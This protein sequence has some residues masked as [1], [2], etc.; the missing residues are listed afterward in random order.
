MVVVLIIGMV[1]G[2]AM[3]SWQMMLPRQQLNSDVRALAA[4]IQGTRSEAIARNDEFRLYYHLDEDRY[5]VETPYRVG[6]GFV[7]REVDEE[8]RLYV[9]ETELSSGVEFVSV[10][11][12]DIEYAN[13]VVFVRFDPLAASSAHTVVLYQELFDR[14]F[15]IEVLA[16][17]GLI[18]FHE[19][20]YERPPAEDADF[21]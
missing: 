19:G 17:T 9:F 5:W 21:D 10:T 15:T 20:I 11:I 2:I 16:L 6:G 14:Y 7:M 8:Q 3:V 4:R 18:K 12:D 1:A 13:G